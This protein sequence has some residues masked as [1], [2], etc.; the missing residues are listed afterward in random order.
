MQV[1]VKKL[2]DV[3]RELKFKISKERVSKALDEVYTELGKFAKIKGFRPG[4]APR[5]LVE[6]Q[7]GKLAQEELIRKL[8]P[9]AY[10]EGLEKEKISPIDYPEIEDVKIDGGVMTFTAK[11]ELRPEINIK[12]YKGIKV[13]RKSSEVTDEDINKTLDFI[14]KGQGEGKEVTIDD[15]FARG[16][17]Y[18]SLEEFKKTMK[19]QME[20]DKD[21][22]NR[23]DVENQIVDNLLSQVKITVP[24]SLINKQLERRVHDAKHRLEHQGLSKDEI[25][26]REDSIRTDLKEAVE[27]DLKVYLVLDKI[28]E[29]E[30]IEV[31]Q[32]EN[33]PAKVMELLLK[34]AKWE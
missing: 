4:K 34:E 6:A 8:V 9:E 10:Q 30:K 32:N 19:R 14:K 11:L 25:N 26:K 33:L 23:Q 3:K 28:A 13:T 20:V 27:K 22:Q 17:G 16:L 18:P 2:D 1:E 5:H 12:N 7:H 31:A 15:A 21:R 29:L 24:Q